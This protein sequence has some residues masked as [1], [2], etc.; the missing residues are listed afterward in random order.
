MLFHVAGFR[1]VST[2]LLKKIMPS[3]RAKYEQILSMRSNFTDYK[4][5]N[6]LSECEAKIVNKEYIT[7]TCSM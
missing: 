6:V 3:N 4:W 5:L 7:P 1:A 2:K